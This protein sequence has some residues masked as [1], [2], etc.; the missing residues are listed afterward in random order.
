MTLFH[1]NFSTGSYFSTNTHLK[2][3]LYGIFLLSIFDFLAVGFLKI[4]FYYFLHAVGFLKNLF[5]CFHNC[6][7]F[8][9][10]F[11]LTFEILTFNF[12]AKFTEF[13]KKLMV[14]HSP[15]SPEPRI[16]KFQNW[17]EMLTSVTSWCSGRLIGSPRQRSRVQDPRSRPLTFMK[18]DTNFRTLHVVGFSCTKEF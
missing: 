12:G 13:P 4:S 6:C 8:K 9:L 3:T 18:A 11:G 15:I 10:H 2:N 16:G 14:F 17:M 7:N 5:V 1:Q